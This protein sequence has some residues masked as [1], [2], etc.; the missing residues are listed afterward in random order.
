MQRERLW[1]PESKTFLEAVFRGTLFRNV[2][3]YLEWCRHTRVM[4]SRDNVYGDN[5]RQERTAQEFDFHRLVT[6]GI[7]L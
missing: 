7:K 1:Y 3:T 5:G 2:V 6:P 4:C